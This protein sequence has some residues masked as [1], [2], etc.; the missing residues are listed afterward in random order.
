MSAN[1]SQLSNVDMK[2]VAMH[3]TYLVL[4]KLDIAFGMANGYGLATV[5]LGSSQGVAK[6][7]LFLTSFNLAAPIQ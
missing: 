1:K 2:S 7:S 4:G 6:N 5:G 3:K